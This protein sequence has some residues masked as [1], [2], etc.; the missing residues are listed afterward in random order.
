MGEFGENVRDI[1]EGLV[2]FLTLGCRDFGNRLQILFRSFA[3]RRQDKAAVAQQLSLGKKAWGLHV[4]STDAYPVVDKIDSIERSVVVK[5]EACDEIEAKAEDLR[6]Q[7]REHVAHYQKELTEQLRVRKPVDAEH[8]EQLVEV[9]RLQRELATTKSEIAEHGNKLEL[10]NK[11]LL[12][13]GT[14]DEERSNDYIRS[15]VEHEIAFIERS[16]QLKRERVE[17]LALRLE[18]KIQGAERS[19]KVVAQFDTLIADLRQRQREGASKIDEALSKLE[20]SCRQIE[21]EIRRLRREMNPLFGELG[22]ELRRRRHEDPE[23]AKE[24]AEIARI[25]RESE[26]LSKEIARLRSDSA[27]IGPGVKI[28]FYGM[29]VLIIALVTWIC[30]LLF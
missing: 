28:G 10:Q 6:R 4:L 8:H 21:R 29:I 18:E 23:L 7:R 3:L 25:E 14:G 17:F 13:I 24:Y 30:F 12:S 5:R 22:M 20:T 26:N 19:G 9:K 27:S 2:G 1:W 15:E 16:L 11:R